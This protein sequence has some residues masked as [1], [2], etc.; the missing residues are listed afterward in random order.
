ME[1][2]G[3]EY[4]RFKDGKRTAFSE[5]IEQYLPTRRLGDL[6]SRWGYINPALIY[7]DY[8]EFRKIKDEVK[9]LK[10]KGVFDRQE[11][12][13]KNFSTKANFF[14]KPIVSFEGLQGEI[15]NKDKVDAVVQKDPPEEFV[16]YKKWRA[17]LKDAENANNEAGNIE[18]KH[19]AKQQDGAKGDISLIFKKD[20]FTIVCFLRDGKTHTQIFT[21]GNMSLDEAK[22]I[23]EKNDE[24]RWLEK[25]SSQLPKDEKW[26]FLNLFE[27]ESGSLEAYYGKYREDKDDF[28]SMRGVLIREKNAPSIQKNRASV[29]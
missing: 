8:D 24:G 5:T 9:E 20:V 29:L 11:Y 18:D 2:K 4:E 16:E 17:T 25:D 3:V 19:L 10:T 21:S 12:V 14:G 28:G 13:K 22:T 15:A 1:E 27:S 26:L 23:M 6:A 7:F